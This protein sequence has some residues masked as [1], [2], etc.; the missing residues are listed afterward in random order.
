MPKHP[1]AKYGFP[2]CYIPNVLTIYEVPINYCSKFVYMKPN[3]VVGKS[4]SCVIVASE[5]FYEIWK[6]DIKG[7]TLSESRTLWKQDYKFP[8]AQ[9]C[10]SIGISN[11]VPAS[12]IGQADHSGVYINDGT[13]RLY[14]LF[15]NM[16]E[17]FPIMCP[18]DSVDFL[19]AQAGIDSF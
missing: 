15:V 19:L 13:T 11:P 4:Y 16:A 12:I 8:S 9:D 5:K 6:A 10:F 1:Y 17:A 2:P 3:V 7:K 14:Y 18:T